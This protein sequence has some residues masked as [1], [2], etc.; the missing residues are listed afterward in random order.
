V[1]AVGEPFAAVATEK[2][3]QVEAA[4][5]KINAGRQHQVAYHRF[6]LKT[7]FG[8][9]D[10]AWPEQPRAHC[11]AGATK[12][13]LRRKRQQVTF[14]PRH[15]GV[16]TADHNVWMDETTSTDPAESAFIV[17]MALLQ[18]HVS[19]APDDPVESAK[20]AFISAIH[21]R[22]SEWSPR[23]AFV[24]GD[25]YRQEGDLNAAERYLQIARESGHQEWAP[26]AEINQGIL[27]MTRGDVQGARRAY[28]AAIATGHPVHAPNAWFNLGT[29][30][31]Q[32]REFPAAIAA[33]RQ[34][35]ASGH[36]T[37]APKAAVNLGFVLFNDLHDQAGAREAFEVAL[38]SGD[39]EQAGLAAMNLAA[40][41]QLAT[42]RAEGH[43]HDQR[44]DGINV[45]EDHEPP[46]KFQRWFKRS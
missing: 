30:Y 25:L 5:L 27:C 14:L 45:A 40:M 37:F 39:Q 36:P 16:G 43:S 26:L 18:G 42:E 28:E 34:A 13:G 9:L 23:A 4:I 19:A 44:D 35:M 21:Y 17:G 46:L 15:A 12:S 3:A 2:P 22:S 6:H 1:S 24:L 33:F 8:D 31:Q 20:G 38:R 7:H 32:Q 11:L 10:Q 29:V 41:D